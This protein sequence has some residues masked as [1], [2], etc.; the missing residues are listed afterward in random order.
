MLL[1]LSF[2]FF[3]CSTLPID[4]ICAL[5]NRRLRHWRVTVNHWEGVFE[6]ISIH[7]NWVILHTRGW[8]VEGGGWRCE[9]KMEGGRW[10]W[11]VRMEGED[12]RWGI[13]IED[14]KSWDG[15]W[16]CRMRMK[17][18][19]WK[20]EKDGRWGIPIEDGESLDGRW[21]CRM[22]MKR[23][24]W[25]VEKGWKSLDWSHHHFRAIGARCHHLINTDEFHKVNEKSFQAQGNVTDLTSSLWRPC[26]KV[27]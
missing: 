23:W 8:K 24:R 16:R 18:W 2:P 12:G 10:G 3:W 13:L 19:R 4:R 14:G 9:V 1:S 6:G 15:R 20:V 21:R 7:E 17:R 27:E 25:K 22:R 11:K 26:H 5:P